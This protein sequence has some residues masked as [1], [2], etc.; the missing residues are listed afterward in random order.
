VS[1]QKQI[2]SISA[3]ANNGIDALKRGEFETARRELEFVAASGRG[4]PSSWV[5][6][7]S[8]YRQ[9]DD[10]QSA[11]R[12]AGKALEIDPNYIPALLFRGDIATAIGDA[13]TAVSFYQGALE[14]A[15]RMPTVPEQY[16]GVLARAQEIC[17]VNAR[18]LE[19]AVRDMLAPHLGAA[20]FA[21]S[22]DL[23]FG[24]TRVF[25]SSPRY[26]YF[27]GLPSIPFPDKSAFPWLAE[28][29]SHTLAIREELLMLQEDHEK[30]APYVERN[31]NRAPKSQGGMQENT[32][33]TACYL[34]KNGEINIEIAER[35]P[36]TLEA[37]KCIPLV[38]TPSR[39]PSV[40]FSVLQPGAHIP[41][42]TG[43]VNTRL[44][45]H[46]P[47]V[48]PRGCRFRVGNQT[49]EW[50]EGEAWLFDDSIEHEAWNDSNEVRTIMIFEVWRPEL[51]SDERSAVC[52]LFEAIDAQS[53]EPPKWEI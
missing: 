39:S 47:L 23:L 41:A 18:Q 31:A 7:A 40:L 29:E 50:R 8:A 35:C 19:T 51:T 17:T 37:I 1:T 5:A 46:L 28:L 32:D 20:R 4:D 21:E 52:K 25:T 13:R 26:F 38:G 42:H 11:S 12:A 3:A 48:V 49:R 34:W 6:L 15:E 22:V 33:W 36:R 24:R 9:L 30:F 43:L 16:R 53:G 44:I 2:D 45:G 10:L 27:P 14:A